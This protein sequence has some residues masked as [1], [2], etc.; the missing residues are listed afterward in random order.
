[1]RLAVRHNLTLSSTSAAEKDQ[2]AFEAAQ[3]EVSDNMT[4]GGTATVRLAAAAQAELVPAGMSAARFVRIAASGSFT[5]SLD[6]DDPI[7]C[8]VVQGHQYAYFIASLAAVASIEIT[9]TSGGT[10]TVISTVV[11]D[12]P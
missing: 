6:A 9:N 12:P 1:M 10:L 11:G 3:Y 7:A 4:E 5:I 8:Q 2:G